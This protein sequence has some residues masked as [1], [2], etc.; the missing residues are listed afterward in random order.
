MIIATG[1]RSCS[2]AEPLPL[3]P[4]PPVWVPPVAA[5]LPAGESVEG[6]IDDGHSDSFLNLMLYIAVII[7]IALSSLGDHGFSLAGRSTHGRKVGANRD[8]P[9]YPDRHRGMARGVLGSG[10][11]LPP[12]GRPAKESRFDPLPPAEP[13]PPSICRGC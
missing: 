7:L 6:G 10:G 13:P 12:F 1:C 11:G 8:R 5:Q 9:R 3:P 4:Y 2:N